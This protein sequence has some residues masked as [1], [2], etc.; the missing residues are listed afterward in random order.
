MAFTTENPVTV[1]D[2][3]KKS[4]Y[5]TVFDNTLYL[6]AQLK[7]KVVDI[8]DWDMDFQGSIAIAHGLTFTNIRSVDVIIRNDDNNLYSQITHM[9]N[10][11]AGYVGDMDATNI[12]VHRITGGPYDNVAYDS[13]SYNRGW[14]T[15][16]YAV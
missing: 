16:W 5:N 8:G 13:T 11:L 12:D 10:A 14:I 2:P 1:G 9:S 3:T 6:Y 7:T 15:I 4:D